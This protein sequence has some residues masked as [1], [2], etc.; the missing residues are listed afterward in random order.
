MNGPLVRHKKEAKYSSAFA[1]KNSQLSFFMPLK[2][3]LPRD[4]VQQHTA[5]TKDETP[6][7]QAKH[8]SVWMVGIED[9]QSAVIVAEAAFVL[10]E[11]GLQGMDVLGMKRLSGLG[12]RAGPKQGVAK[13]PPPPYRGSSSKGV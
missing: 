4:T 11:K 8:V 3:I 13:Q 2:D 5:V 10:V 7:K 12:V 1:K 9:V 6:R